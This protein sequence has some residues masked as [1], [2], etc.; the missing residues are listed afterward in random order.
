M[1]P[2]DYMSQ[3]DEQGK[4]YVVSFNFLGFPTVNRATVLSHSEK[5]M[6]IQHRNRDQNPNPWFVNL[7]NVAKIE[8]EV[9]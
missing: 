1:N 7:R 8:I 3:L 6:Q 5:W 9:L 2:H 4:S